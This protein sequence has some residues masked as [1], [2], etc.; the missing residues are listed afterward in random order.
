MN[1]PLELEIER[2]SAE[3][4]DEW[5]R[6]VALSKNSTFLFDRDYMDYHA[7][8][9]EDHSLMIYRRGRLFALLPA[10]REGGTLFSHHGLSY[11]GLLVSDKATAHDTCL[12][13]AAVNNRLRDEGF[14]KV[15]YKAIP[16]IYNTIPADEP[17]Y[18]ITEVCHA[19]IT[20]RDIASVIALDHQ[21]RMSELRR[22][23]M[24]KAQAAGVT[25]RWCD[26]LPAFWTLLSDNLREKY[27]ASPVHTLQEIG[28]L[29]GR[30]PDSI[31]LFAAF[32][33]DE[34][35]AGTLL[36]VTPQVVKTQYISASPHGKE[37]GALD[38][39]FAQLKAAPPGRQQFLDM[40]TSALDHSTALKL[41]LIFQKEGFGARAV[42]YDTYEWTL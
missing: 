36:Y 10:N 40:G 14:A 9:F 39:L 38:L 16:Y 27:N 12:A 8:R 34:M 6:F 23:G 11:G 24:R 41:P 33:G 31:R 5:N 28:L 17:L 26:D 35:V 22:R 7:D 18:A 2:Y 30:F 3:R 13:M 4:K 37:I 15:V 42:C 1:S 20:A 25:L 29:Q 32:V 19:C 21:P